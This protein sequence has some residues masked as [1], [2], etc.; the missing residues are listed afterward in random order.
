MEKTGLIAP[1]DNLKNTKIWVESTSLDMVVNERIVD[2]VVDFYHAL[3]N[4]KK[5]TYR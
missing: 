1:L 3:G 4:D 2:K 5:L